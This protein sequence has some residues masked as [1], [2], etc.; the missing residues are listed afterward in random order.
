MIL[1]DP[2]LP[3]KVSIDSLT[4]WLTWPRNFFVLCWVFGFGF[5][6]LAYPY[7]PDGPET[8]PWYHIMHKKGGGKQ[9]F[10][11]F[12]CFKNKATLSWLSFFPALGGRFFHKWRQ[13]LWSKSRS[14]CLSYVIRLTR[15]ENPCC[16]HSSSSV[17]SKLSYS[18]LADRVIGIFVWFFP[19]IFATTS[20][21]SS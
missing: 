6:L 17:F 4:D 18:D 13:W 5:G 12:C 10:L 16:F 9:V 11:R 8:I 15:C 14:H 3:D 20:A 2:F 1:R 21:I 7:E 19:Y